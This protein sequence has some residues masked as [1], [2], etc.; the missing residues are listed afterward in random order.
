MLQKITRP[1]SAR[2][3]MLNKHDPGCSKSRKR[4]H[5]K[6][7]RAKKALAHKKKRSAEKAGSYINIQHS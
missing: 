3:F 7:A 5:K 6:S 1:E 2:V 4:D